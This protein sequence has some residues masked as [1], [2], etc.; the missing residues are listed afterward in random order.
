MACFNQFE[1]FQF[2]TAYL[3][4]ILYGHWLVDNQLGEDL[5]VCPISDDRIEIHCHGGQAATDVIANSLLSRGAT[6]VEVVELASRLYKSEYLADFEMSLFQ[7]RTWKTAQLLIQQRQN[8]KALFNRHYELANTNE[9]DRLSD[10]LDACLSWSDFGKKLTQSRSVVLCGRPNV[11]KSSLVNRLVG[12]QRAIVHSEAGTTRDV[13]YQETAIDGWP[14]KIVDTAG[15]RETEIE[16]EKAGIMLASEQI[17]CADLV[18]LVVDATDDIDGQ[19]NEFT[20]GGDTDLVIANKS[21]LNAP[22]SERLDL[23]VSAKENVGVEALIGLIAQ[24][25]SPEMPPKNQAF[26]ISSSQIDFFHT[27][28]GAA[29]SG[30]WEIFKAMLKNVGL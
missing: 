15:I 26:P 2:Q 11:G 22:I 24:K 30:E 28:K 6:R 21:D 3:G 19:I 13:V 29:I 12:F 23:A 27:L 10:E 8:Q 18:V 25:L 20:V 5:V 4:K 9:V 14:V 16:I 7:A 1:T 17:A